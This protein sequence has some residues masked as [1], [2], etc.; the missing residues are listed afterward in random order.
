MALIIAASNFNSFSDV[1]L[2]MKKMHS[3]KTVKLILPT[4]AQITKILRLSR[5]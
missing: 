3:H 5:S 1:F 2:I 4:P